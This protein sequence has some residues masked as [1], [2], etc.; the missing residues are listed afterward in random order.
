MEYIIQCNFD[1]KE[2]NSIIEEEKY[3]FIKKIFNLSSFPVDEVMPDNYQDFDVEKHQSLREILNK[4]N[5][6]ILNYRFK[7]FEIYLESDLI[8][9]FYHPQYT[10]RR[11]LLAKEN[12]KKIF[13]E[14]AIKTWSVFD[15]E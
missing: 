1:L 11:D 13:A 2:I 9:K 5:I 6:S 3:N 7:E 14:I 4:Y 12:S 10:L 15:E 8:A